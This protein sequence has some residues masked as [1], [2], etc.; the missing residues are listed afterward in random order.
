[1][2]FPDINYLA[3]LVS[4]IVIFMLGG[5]WYSRTLFASRWIAAMGTTEEQLRAAAGKSSMAVS[6]VLVFLCGLLTA[7]VL[8]IVVVMFNAGDPVA[9]AITGML[10]WLGFAGATSF[11]TA[12]FSFQPRQ[13][14][15]INSGYNLVSLILAG[16]ILAVWR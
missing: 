14:W 8:A 10:C 4:G 13:L 11:G 5:L 1:M 12:L 3:V 2:T 7:W 6:Y 16:I 9:G 15:L